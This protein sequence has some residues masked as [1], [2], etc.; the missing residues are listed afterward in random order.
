MSDLTD[1]LDQ[2]HDN[3]HEIRDMVR[4]AEIAD[5]STLYIEP[6]Q[7]P[8][9]HGRAT[10]PSLVLGCRDHGVLIYYQWG[11]GGRVALTDLMLDVRKHLESHH[12]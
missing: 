6:N 4:F 3:A 10:G 12:G 1:L 11:G 7:E 5:P 2:I 8:A 9:P